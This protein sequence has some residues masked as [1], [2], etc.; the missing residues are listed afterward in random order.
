MWT[1]KK[2]VYDVSLVTTKTMGVIEFLQGLLLKQTTQIVINKDEVVDLVY[3]KNEDITLVESI[4]ISSVSNPVS[5]SS[6][7][8]ETVTE[9]PLDYA[10]SFVAG[11]LNTPTGTE[12]V[13]ILNGSPLR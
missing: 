5:E 11:P 7:L 12:R 1:D 13:F 3:A 2:L 8:V 10:V 9:Q 4:V 6:T